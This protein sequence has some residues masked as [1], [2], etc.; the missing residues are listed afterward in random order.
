MIENLSQFDTVE[1]YKD[2]W[3]MT[4]DLSKGFAWFKYGERID[5]DGFRFPEVT[6]RRAT[7]Q[8]LSNGTERSAGWQPMYQD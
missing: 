1:E 5:E 6:L 4:C 3:V 8:I 2:V 7:V